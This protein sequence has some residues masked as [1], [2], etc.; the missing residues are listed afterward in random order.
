MRKSIADLLKRG[1]RVGQPDVGGHE[2]VEPEIPLPAGVSRE[3]V[4][5]ILDAIDEINRTTSNSVVA[6]QKV[7]EAFVDTLLY[8]DEQTYEYIYTDC[9]ATFVEDC[10]E[11]LR[12]MSEIGAERHSKLKTSF[13]LASVLGAPSVD[14]INTS[15]RVLYQVIDRGWWDNM[16]RAVDLCKQVKGKNTR[17][18]CIKIVDIYLLK[19]TIDNVTL[20]GSREFAVKGAELIQD[21]KLRQAGLGAAR[22]PDA[23]IMVRGFEMPPGQY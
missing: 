4:E 11:H 22:N 6:I 23:M 3:A 14:D 21:N 15:L 13:P 17:S 7:L 18:A 1:E 12:E 16:T 8:A 10:R 5:K 2:P 19:R 20:N 9:V